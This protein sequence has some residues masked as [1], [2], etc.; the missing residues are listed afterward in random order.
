MTLG[1]FLARG[2][3]CAGGCVITID[4]G[5]LSAAT[6]LFPALAGADLTAVIFPVAGMV[7]RKGWV[8]WTALAEMR[9]A[10]FEV[11]SHGMTH[12][13]LA[14]ASAREE[15]AAS[16]R[17]IEDR[18]GAPVQYLALPGGTEP[19]DGVVRRGGRLHGD[20]RLPL[21]LQQG[22]RGADGSEKD[23]PETRGRPRAAAVFAAGRPGRIAGR[24]MRE[25]GKEIGRAILGPRIYAA[26]R[27]RLVPEGAC[28]SL[29]RFP[30]DT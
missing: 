20:L 23:L 4:D 25:R 8:D 22:P 13:S 26:L 28:R 7:G 24:F 19:R 15:L 29:P 12:A 2:G 6:V 14:A 11:G 21:R 27:G 17:R 10:G 18:L 3:Y 16:K 30:Q 9:Q 5:L 1:E